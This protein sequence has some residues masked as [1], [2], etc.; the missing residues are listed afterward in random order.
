MTER[1]TVHMFRES[2]VGNLYV[3]NVEGLL[4]VSDDTLAG[5]LATLL[6]WHMSSKAIR[7]LANGLADDLNV[8]EDDLYSLICD[9]A[10]K[11]SKR[12]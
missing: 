8:D 3:K 11:N 9:W 2:P 10:Q 12:L 6:W 7:G 1:N 5:E 4:E